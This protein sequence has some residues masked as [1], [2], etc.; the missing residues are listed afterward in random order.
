VNV[1]TYFTNASVVVQIVMLL[2]LLSSIFSWT[3]I[4]QRALILARLQKMMLA[5]EDLF[6]SG[7]DLRQ[8]YQ[9]LLH[10][11]KKENVGLARIFTAG[12]SQWQQLKQKNVDQQQLM[13]NTQ[14]AMRIAYTQELKQ[15]DQH[16]PWLA[17]IGSTSPYVGLLGTVW[18]IMTSFQS[19][20]STQTTLTIA[21]VAPG[22]SEALV[23]TA[24]GLFA[25]IPAVIFYNRYNDWI[26]RLSIQY[27]NFQEEC[28]RI[29]SNHE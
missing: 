26:E 24:M 4:V 3:I 23:A 14:R 11:P 25:A 1:L 21:A 12:F 17:T 7:L 18:G 29:L 22:I 16:L 19:L 5:F 27:Y 28:L 8:L 9:D 15:L 6:W 10:Q 2:L 13:D 20:A